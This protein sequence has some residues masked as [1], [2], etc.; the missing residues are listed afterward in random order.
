MLY[1]GPKLKSGITL[2]GKDILEYDPFEIK[3]WI[4]SLPKKEA[5]LIREFIR[6]KM[7]PDD[8]PKD[9]AKA[10]G[11]PS[12]KE[13]PYMTCENDGY[14]YIPGHSPA[15][16]GTLSYK[17]NIYTKRKI[18]WCMWSNMTFKDSPLWKLYNKLSYPE[19]VKVM[20]GGSL[21]DTLKKKRIKFKK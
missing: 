20:N 2:N 18:C 5:K 7:I 12:L 4:S 13:R 8:L 9:Y 19:F 6:N 3:D 14:P 15:C 11:R 1:K 16:D 21:A 10:Y 17:E